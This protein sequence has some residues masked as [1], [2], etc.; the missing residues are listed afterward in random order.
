MGI[1]LIFQSVSEAFIL[2]VGELE[3]ANQVWKNTCQE[4]ITSIIKKKT[5]KLVDLQ[6]IGIQ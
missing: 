3:T 6:P 5:W 1:T 4:E 2:Q